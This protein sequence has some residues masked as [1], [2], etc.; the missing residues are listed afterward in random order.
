MNT[1]EQGPLR[2]DKITFSSLFV[3]NALSYILVLWLGCKAQNEIS[4][5]VSESF[6]GMNSTIMCRFT[7]I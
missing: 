7:E 6:S 5:V 1:G 4:I 2:E 3:Y